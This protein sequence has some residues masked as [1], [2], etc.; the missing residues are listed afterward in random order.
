MNARVQEFT[1]GPLTL[2]EMIK[3]VSL[4]ENPPE[5]FRVRRALR[6]YEVPQRLDD[7]EAYKWGTTPDLIK[8]LKHYALPQNKDELAWM[9]GYVKDASSLLEIGSSFGGTLSRMASVM[10]KGSRIVSVDL[11]C[12]DTPKFL[13]PVASLKETCR[14]IAALGGNVELLIG[15]SHSAAVVEKVRE[16]GPFDFVLIDGDHSYEGVKQDWENYGPMGKIVGFHDINQ[17]SEVA[18]FWQQLCASGQYR[19]DE[20]KIG[21]GIGLVFREESA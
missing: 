11:A 17:V 2:D 10:P 16:L 19:T 21:F 13:N 3:I 15:D 8:Y 4:M 12:D 6:F 20:R 5:A 14:Q 7:P 1:E 9:L 18:A